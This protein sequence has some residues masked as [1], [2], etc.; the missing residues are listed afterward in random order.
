MNIKNIFSLYVFLCFTCTS[1]TQVETG[2]VKIKDGTLHYRIYG[3]GKPLLFMNGGPGFSSK[4]YEMVAKQLENNRQVILFDPRGTG[5]S[6]LYDNNS[7]TINIRK[8]VDDIEKLRIH[9]NI[10]KLD[11]MGHS[12]GGVYAMYYAAKYPERI[13]KIVCTATL[14]PNKKRFDDIPKFKEVADSLLL[15]REKEFKAELKNT[16][17]DERYRTQLAIR[18]RNYVHRKENIPFAIDWFYTQADFTRGV[19]RLVYKSIRNRGIKKKLK[20]F[21][22]PVLIIY[23]EHDFILKKASLTLHGTLP[24][25][26]WVSIPN[27]GHFLWKEEP[28]KT[29][30]IILE[31]LD[32]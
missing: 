16:K 23:P 20:K 1:L 15:P 27:C 26:K 28:Q 2:H 12:F 19:Y 29:K 22:Q 18:A 6:S 24:N 17:G 5:N 25:S 31:F 10:E 7:L 30:D 14:G 4:G 32:D 13:N 11:I 8:M 3:K 21:E 9:L